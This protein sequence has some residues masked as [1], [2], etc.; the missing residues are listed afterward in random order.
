MLP[1]DRTVPY[2]LVIV[3]AMDLPT[4]SW[5]VVQDGLYHVIV[6]CSHQCVPATCTPPSAGDR[7][8]V[9]GYVLV[10]STDISRQLDWILL[11][12]DCHQQCRCDMS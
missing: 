11:N 2:C 9:R 1:C 3:P 7:L 4:Q 12:K 5:R 10:T 6:R 8:A